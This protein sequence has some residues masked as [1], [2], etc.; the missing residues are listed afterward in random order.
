M[1]STEMHA[2]IYTYVKSHVY[3]CLCVHAHKHTRGSCCHAEPQILHTSELPDPSGILGSCTPLIHC[4]W[5]QKSYLKLVVKYRLPIQD[6]FPILNRPQKHPQEGGQGIEQCRVS[7][8]AFNP[9]YYLVVSKK[10]AL[11]FFLSSLSFPL[12]FS[13]FLSDSP[14]FF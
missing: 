6:S 11:S 1:Y 12:S 2:Y 4:S 8:E 5:K 7:A 10:G 14:V 3:T 9:S 13:L